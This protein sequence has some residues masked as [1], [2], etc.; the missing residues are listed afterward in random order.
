MQLVVGTLSTWSSRAWICSQLAGVKLDLIWIDLSKSGYKTEV[1][2]YAPTGLVPALLDDGLVVH[3][4][5]AIVEYLN[6]LSGGALYP[7]D[8]SQRAIARSLCM[9]MHAGFM[10]LRSQCPF[11]LGAVAPLVDIND[12]IQIEIS[13]VEAIFSQA[14]LPFMFEQAGAVDAFYA[15]L[16]YRLQSYGIVLEGKAGE[17][18]QSLLEWPLLQQAIKLR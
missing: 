10:N 6:E 5:L 12:S 18:Q 8:S 15:I 14:K 16:A 4:S 7:V 9:E 3:D 11:S 1:L 17:Y 2:K 13:R